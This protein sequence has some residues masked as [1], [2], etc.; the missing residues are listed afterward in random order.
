MRIDVCLAERS[1]PNSRRQPIKSLVALDAHAAR[2]SSAPR[3]WTE[4]G[5]VT[6]SLRRTSDGGVSCFDFL[7]A[8]SDWGRSVMRRRFLWP[9]RRRASFLLPG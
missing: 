2:L 8:L 5:P 6:I 9:S 1:R 7:L 3:V 4:A